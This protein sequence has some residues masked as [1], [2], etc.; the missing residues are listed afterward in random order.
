MDKFF[1]TLIVKF[2]S[3]CNLN[4]S[5]CYEYNTGDDSWKKKPKHFSV[6]NAKILNK[7]IREYLSITK[8]KKINIVAHGGEPLLIGPDKLNDILSEIGL[9]IEENI[10]F[11][12][13]TNAVL[14]NPK[15]I[16]VLKKHN[17][18]CGVSIDGSSY[19]NRHRVFHNGKPTYDETVKGYKLLNDNNLVAGILCVVDFQTN[20]KEV[21]ESICSLKPKQIDLLQPFFNHDNIN[22][23]GLGKSFYNWFSKAFDYYITKPEWHDIQIRIFEAALY[24]IFSEKSNSDWF[25]G[26]HG[27]YLVIE[28]DGNFD[29]LDHL[30]SI[31][32][33]GK[34]ISNLKMNLH[35]N[36]LIDANQ[37][38]RNIYHDCDIKS[39][40]D[41]CNSCKFR[42][43]C[44]GG[45]Y[46]TRFSSEN[47]SLNNVSVYCSGL[48][49]FFSKL[50]KQYP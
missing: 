35:K 1:N 8:L 39:P 28:T 10:N 15:I 45:Y 24:S 17:V 14:V 30:K 20:P 3:P 21:L 6:E 9:G 5:Y 37:K 41:S 47:N 12:M 31:G 38:I 22:A 50:E 33:F 44:G 4:C 29:I 46:P 25:G 34:E 36:S 11:G 7:R 40:P 32:S 48:Y 23:K 19:H 2:A 27:N 16:E 13:Q 43:K 49:D 42:L 26:P 18:K